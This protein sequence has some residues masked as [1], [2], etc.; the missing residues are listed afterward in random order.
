MKRILSLIILIMLCTSL[1]ACSNDN[2]SDA[3]NVITDTMVRYNCKDNTCYNKDIKEESADWISRHNGFELGALEL[4]GCERDGDKYKIVSDKDFKIKYLV[5]QSLGSLSTEGG[6]KNGAESLW[7]NNDGSA[8]VLGTD[9]TSTVGIGACFVKVKYTDGSESSFSKTDFFK[10]AE[11]NSHLD[12]IKS[13]NIDKEKS[14]AL[15]EVTVVYEMYSGGPGL[16]GIW[17]HE[18]TNWRCEHTYVF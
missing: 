1:F 3:K 12:I 15:I 10:D 8:G 2:S 9:I 11:K 13:K 7:V 4:H 18:Y 6:S 17:W 5:T 14:L 16:F